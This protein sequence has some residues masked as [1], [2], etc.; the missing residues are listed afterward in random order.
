[1]GEKGI[2]AASSND[3]IRVVIAS[4]DS[5][6]RMGLRAVVEREQNTRIVGEAEAHANAEELVRVHNPNVVILAE[7]VHDTELP[8]VVRR[9]LK[10]QPTIR[11]VILGATAYPKIL[12]EMLTAGVTAY[13]AKPHAASEMP[14]A[15]EA[16]RS[17]K[18]FVSSALRG[19]AGDDQPN[20]HRLA[21]LSVREREV[22]KLLADGRT[23]R[24]IAAA[25]GISAR[26]VESH[27]A[28]ICSK[29]AIHTIAELTKLA[30]RE[31]LTT[32]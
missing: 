7:G 18:T 11:I 17:G 21:V 15:F 13:I 5:L 24:Q 1:M 23:S 19:R 4:R 20:N 32:I 14:S 12:S 28:Q 26:T 6:E 29:L 25:L 22:L 16:A 2:M 10:L 27:R 3:A 8:T 30:I 9:I 31:G